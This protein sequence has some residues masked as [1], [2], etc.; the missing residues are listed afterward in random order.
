MLIEQSFDDQIPSIF[1]LLLFL[2]NKA[3]NKSKKVTIKV[4][5]KLNINRKKIIKKINIDCEMLL[6]I[7]PIKP[8]ENKFAS[9][10][11]F[12]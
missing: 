3:V 4:T 1:Y 12:S 8:A 7:G 5:L 9:E 6:I 2:I 10:L 11:I